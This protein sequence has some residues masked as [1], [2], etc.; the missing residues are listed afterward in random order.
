MEPKISQARPGVAAR[1]PVELPS[2]VV[3]RV[4]DPSS[5]PVLIVLG[6]IH[7]NEP[8]GYYGLLSVFS[9]LEKMPV[10][11]RGS[12][13][14][15]IGNRQALAEGVR[16]VEED[17]NR[18]WSP[19]SVAFNQAKQTHAGELAEA[20][21]LYL[22]I[23]RTLEQ[24]QDSVY[25]LDIH[26]TSGEG[27]AFVLFD[28]TLANREF[29]LEL[30]V[31]MVLGI[32]EELEGTLLDYLNTRGVITAG[33][34][35]GQH[36]D[37]ASA[38]R[39]AAAV[40]VAMRASGVL[41]RSCEA[42]VDDA[43]RRLAARDRHLPH[44]FE[45]R[46]RHAIRPHAGFKMLPGL[47]GFQ[48]VAKGDK[49]AVEAGAPVR[50]PEGGLLLMPRYQAQGEDGYFVIRPV[51]SLWLGISARLRRLRVDRWVH[52]LPGVRRLDAGGREIE[53]NIRI[54][55]WLPLDFF[56]LLGYRRIGQVGRRIF[57]RR[58]PDDWLESS[59]VGPIVA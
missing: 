39:A 56:H 5:G 21:D 45:V 19:E 2:R 23:E 16:F 14:G 38:E 28:D 50:A 55:R 29:A 34:E 36:N 46:Y 48:L 44:L 52:W 57:L 51:R 24:A 33:F 6:A 13:V 42:E 11:L 31:P 30:E 26:S 27:P 58:R 20:H 8:A 41:G 15:L 53:V 3:G 40:W 10:E 49:V 1:R 17:L 18:M 7:G 43:S 47:S 4:G 59:A 12:V 22:E 54:A 37:P 9:R 25:A 35:A 32:E